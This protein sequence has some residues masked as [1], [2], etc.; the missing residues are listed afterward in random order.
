MQLE[1]FSIP[2]PDFAA[3]TGEVPSTVQ[4]HE[5]RYQAHRRPPEQHGKPREYRLQDGLRTM[6]VAGLRQAGIE[7]AKA[8]AVAMDRDALADFM[9]GRPAAFGLIAK[10]PLGAF[11]SRTPVI[12]VPLEHEGQRLVNGFTAYMIRA[13]GGPAAAVALDDFDA[14]CRALRGA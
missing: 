12:S 1:D 14:R 10:V 11:D 4:V 3:L 5:T 9:A 7:P 13:H 8:W 2:L 6:I